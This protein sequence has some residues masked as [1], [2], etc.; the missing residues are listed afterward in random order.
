MMV[1]MD[2][3]YLA[4]DTDKWQDIVVGFHKMREFID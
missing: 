3:I 1:D 4:Q 2:V